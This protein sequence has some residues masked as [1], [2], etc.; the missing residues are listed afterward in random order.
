M[1]KV[2]ISGVGCCLLDYLYSN[3]DF[4]GPQFSKYLS[5]KEGD[6]GLSP[7]R[8]VFTEELEKFSN[9]PIKEI[10][11]D[12]VSNREPDEYNSDHQVPQNL[13]LPESR[14]SRIVRRYHEVPAPS[15]PG[16]SFP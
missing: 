15:C 5:V 2:K 4:K 12:L 10:L 16:H 3:I 11:S 8:L 9:K 14:S 7:G 6:G 1:G 13:V